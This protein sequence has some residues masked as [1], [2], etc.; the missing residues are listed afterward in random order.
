MGSGEVSGNG[1]VYWTI[2]H[3]ESVDLRVSDNNSSRPPKTGETN[4]HTKRKAQGRDAIQVGDV[5]RKK[6]HTGK[7]RVKLRFESNAAAQDAVRGASPFFDSAAGMWTI[8]VDVPV[9]PRQDPDDGPP[10]EVRIDW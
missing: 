5:G 6:G 1:S 8:V 10:S 3:E 7:F 2:D 4:V 9:V